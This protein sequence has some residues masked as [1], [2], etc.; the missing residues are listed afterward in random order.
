M[1]P[2]LTLVPSCRGVPEDALRDL[3]DLVNRTSGVTLAPIHVPS[4]A[5]LPRVLEEMPGA[6]AWSPAYAASILVR[7]R[8]ASALVA[9][10]RGDRGVRSAVLLGRPGIEGLAD[11]AGRRIGW[12]SRVSETGYQVPWLY[13]ESFGVDPAELFATERFCGTHAGAVSALVRGDVD[14]I[15]THSGRL[16]DA[17]ARTP[18]RLVASIGHLPA[19]VIVAGPEVPPRLRGELTAALLPLTWAAHSFAPVRDGH[20][21]LFDALRRQARELRDPSRGATALAVR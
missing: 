12:V 10:R 18:V 11:L 8:E 13:L 3:R 15:A 1:E 20:L 5:L 9:V 6:V 2:L 19:D 17:F 16:R 21:G 7:H 4:A 14:V